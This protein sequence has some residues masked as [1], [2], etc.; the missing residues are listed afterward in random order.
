MPRTPQP[1][2]ALHWCFT[3]NNPNVSEDVF[4]AAIQEHWNVKYC[5]FQ[6]E[7]G[8]NLTPHYQGSPPLQKVYS[9]L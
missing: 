3:W 1:A 8:V 7:V 6:R 9:L 5:V 2:R 4:A